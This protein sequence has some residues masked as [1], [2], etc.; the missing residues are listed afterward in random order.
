MIHTASP[1]RIYRA[2]VTASFW[3]VMLSLFAAPHAFAATG[4]DAALSMKVAQIGSGGDPLKLQWTVTVTNVGTQ[5][6][7]FTD[8]A[9]SS[10]DFSHLDIPS[11]FGGVLG[12]G[13]FG[14]DQLTFLPGSESFA[15]H[16]A[17]APNL[18]FEGSGPGS[19]TGYTAVDDQ[20]E[21]VLGGTLAVGEHASVSLETDT[22]DPGVCP[23]GLDAL[24]TPATSTDDTSSPNNSASASFGCPAETGNI[25]LSKKLT[26]NTST[27]PGFAQAGAQLTYLITSVNTTSSYADFT[28][29]DPV[30]A[31]TTYVSSSCNLCGVAAFFSNNTVH[32]NNMSI[33]PNGEATFTVVVQVN[34]PIPDGVTSIA[35]VAYDPAK[36]IPACPGASAQCVS[37]PTVSSVTLSKALT[38]NTGPIAGEASPGAQLT[39]TITADNSGGAAATGYSITDAL[40]ANTTFVSATNGGAVSG[41]TVVWSNLT[42]PASGFTT[43]SVTVQINNPLPAGSV[44]ANVAYETGNSVPP[45]PGPSTSCVVT[46]TAP[47]VS[48]TKT[49]TGNTSATPGEASPNASLTYTVTATNT[50]STAATGYGISDAV[51]ANTSFVSATSGGTLSG[52]I[53]NW[54]NLTVPANGSVSVS[55]TDKVAAVIPAGVTSI[56]NVAYQTG[57]SVPPCPGTSP[58]CVTTPTVSDLVLTKTLTGNS[59]TMPG[60]ATGGAQL[61]YTITVQNIGGSSATGVVVDE[62]VPANTTYDSTGSSPWSCANGSGAGTLCLSPSQTLAAGATLTLTFVI[63]VVDPIPA[64]VTSIGNSA[65]LGTPPPPCVANSPACVVIPTPSDLIVTKKLTHESGTQPGIAE[66]GETLTYTITVQNAGGS[67]ATN[68]SVNEMVPTHTT[69]TSAGSS[70]WSCAN[71]SAAGTACSIIEPSIAANTTTTVTFAIIVDNPIPAGVV[72]IANAV[73]ANAPAP[74]CTTPSTTCVITPTASNVTLMKTLTGHQGPNAAVVTAGDLLT[75]SIVATNSGGAS[76]SAVQIDEQVPMYTNYVAAGSSAWSCANNSAGGTPC[77]FT[78]ASLGAGKSQTLTF[79]IRA[80]SPLP[81]GATSI[82]NG[83]AIGTTP[84]C[85]ASS[86]TCVILPVSPLLTV[87]KTVSAQAILPG[88]PVTWTLMVVNSGTGTSGAVDIVDDVPVGA[89]NVTASGASPFT[90]TTSGNHV[91]CSAAAVAPG[92]YALTINATAPMTPGPL[93][94]TCTATADAATIDTSACTVSTTISGLP[95]VVMSKTASAAKLKTNS[96]IS[97]SINVDN[98]GPGNASNVVITDAVPAGVSAVT[99]A[100]AGW[101]CTASANIVSC[102]TATLSVGTSSIAVSGTTPGSAATLTNTCTATAANGVTPDTTACKATTQ[103]TAVTPPPPPPPVGPPLTGVSAIPTLS[104]WGLLAMI[105]SL[106]LLSGVILRR[107]KQ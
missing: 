42:I 45:C 31:N 88:D 101:A 95:V 35:N 18:T 32:W 64:G 89:T 43:V 23:R 8:H 94:N 106:G 86:S 36:T 54:T 11:T 2:F 17:T 82:A 97:W 4:C 12:N 16:Q 77:S 50:G 48:L 66:P 55:V 1:R 99:A 84:T 30:P 19:T 81:A 87:T 33:V 40:P 71:G 78:I 37:T 20:A 29:V 39:Y 5:T 52:N 96:A 70:T 6:C 41:N 15:S 68:V 83:V 105:V 22:V 27:V 65:A 53:V 69:F 14:N 72:S 107:R 98:E 7:D 21:Y 10:T 91:D 25:V 73:A 46:Q 44:I 60:F 56:S 67:A 59:G 76:A 85:T 28:L 63:D 90:C 57:N 51:P 100:G 49:L 102:S 3:L 47:N 103:V 79:V 93:G 38:G 92:T 62:K 34:T 75:Y 13:G 80:E 9:L 26:G 104:Q 74:S 58:S 61:T 24:L